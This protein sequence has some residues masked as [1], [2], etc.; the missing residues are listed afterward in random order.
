MDLL[1][2][3]VLFL[4]LALGAAALPASSEMYP[5]DAFMARIASHCGQAFAGR[6]VANEPPQPD[7]PFAGKTLVMHVR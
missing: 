3:C 2:R 5:P 1:N 7:D 4:C 6:I